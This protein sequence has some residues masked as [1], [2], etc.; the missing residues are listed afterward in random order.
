MGLFDRLSKEGRA[1][2]AIE[3]N[4]KKVLNKHI[5]HEDRVAAME[6]LRE[7]ANAGEEEAM[8]GLA[9]RYS[10]VYDKT[11]LDEKEKAWVSDALVALGPK[12]VGA[13]R[14]YAKVAETLSQLLSVMEQ[15]ADKETLLSIVDELLAREEPGYTRDPSKMIQLLLWLQE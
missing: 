5:Q 12:A 15:I 8:I 7:A 11:I 10:Y 3:K 9:R 14:R 2:S 13:L 6:K 4:T 1:K